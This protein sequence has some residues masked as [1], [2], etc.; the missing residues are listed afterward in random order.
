MQATASEGLAQGPCM[1]ARAGFEDT[2]LRTKGD[3]S[4]NVPRRYYN[5][6]KFIIS[7]KLLYQ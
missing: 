5:T 4:T 2:T 6:F 7:I 1:A 3:K